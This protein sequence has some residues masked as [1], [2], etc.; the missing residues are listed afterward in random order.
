MLRL[1]ITARS[2]R[3]I[4]LTAQTARQAR[5]TWARNALARQNFDPAHAER[6]LF[7]L[8]SMGVPQADAERTIHQALAAAAAAYRIHILTIGAEVASDSE[9][10]DT[11]RM[12]SVSR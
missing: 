1:I 6:D 11:G 2:K 3:A 10:T 8:T 9:N 7:I 12:T 5:L 4:A